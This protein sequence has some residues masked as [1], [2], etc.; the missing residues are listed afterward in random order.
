MKINIGFFNIGEKG[1]G[2][3][4]WNE[5][6]NEKMGGNKLKIN[7]KV[8]DKTPANQKV[9][10]DTSNIPMKKVNDQDRE[11]FINNIES[12]DFENYK[13]IRG[14]SKSVRYKKS[15]TNYKKR[16]LEGQ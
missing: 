12:H 3:I 13:A 4:T 10:T 15:K 5:F 14:E 8:F 9:L 11:I 2:D 6:A 16:N 7:E 1:H